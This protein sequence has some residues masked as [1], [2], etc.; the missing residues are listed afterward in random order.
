LIRLDARSARYILASA[1]LVPG[2]NPAAIYHAWQEGFF[3]LL[4]CAEQ[5]DELRATL[6]KPRMA[7]RIKPYQAGSLVNEWKELAENIGSLP[8]ASKADYLVTCDRNGLLPLSRHKATRIVFRE[9]LL[10]F[11]RMNFSLRSEKLG[12]LQRKHNAQ[13]RLYPTNRADQWHIADAETSRER[14]YVDLVESGRS[15]SGEGWDHRD[16]VD[17]QLD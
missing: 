9:L 16:V 15:N 13:R 17:R 10:G 5:L 3:T 2:G 11:V 7:L 4:V 14:H 6:L 12:L 1:L 8:R